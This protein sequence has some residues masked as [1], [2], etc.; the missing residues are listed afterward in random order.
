MDRHISPT[1]KRIL[2]ILFVLAVSLALRVINLDA[3]PSALISR[4]FIT[5]EG[6]WAHNARNAVI[7]DQL[8]VDDYNPGLYSAFLYHN[9]LQLAFSAFGMSIVSARLVSAVAGWFTVVLLFDWIRREIDT[10]TAVIGALLL[11][12]STL[13]VLYSRTGFVE[14]TLVFFLALALWLWSI[15]RKHPAFGALSGIAFDLMVVT[16]VTAIYIVPGIALLAVAEA[17][18]KT[19]SKRD[20][21]LFICGASIVF[22]S[23][24]V[25]FVI[26]NYTSWIDYNLAAGFDNEFPRHW[27]ELVHSVL[28]LLASRFFARVPILTAL[29]LV[30]L[31]ALVFRISISG[32]KNAVRNACGIEITAIALL[33]GYLLSIAP[34]VYQPERRFVPVLFLMVPISANALVRGWDWFEELANEPGL[35]AV[36]W[37]LFLFSLPTLAIIEL[38]WAVL[39]TPLTFRSWLLKA[40]PVLLLIF[41]SVSLGRG[42]LSHAVRGRLL[43][44][45]KLVFVVLFSGLSLGLVYQSLRLWGFNPHNFRPG[46]FVVG[47]TV[48]AIVIAAIFGLK[49]KPKAAQVA[50]AAFVSIEALQT[51]TWFLQQTYTLK[52]ANEALVGIVKDGQTVIT[53]YETMLLSSTARTICYW[54]RA[55]FNVD[56][57]ERFNPDYI[58][59]LRRDN[60]TDHTLGDMPTDEWPPPTSAAPEFVAR[61]DLCPTETRGFRFSLELYRLVP[62]ELVPTIR[63]DGSDNRELMSTSSN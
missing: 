46:G 7:F 54:P 59:I 58:L 55:G 57:F 50:L 19:T 26:P 15:R 38:K 6:Q 41:V 2:L 22:A 28:S 5:D 40:I 9:L 60:W 39:G 1:Q 3:D 10:R 49:I 11:G 37:F 61:F 18:R 8:R 12:L 63:S 44:G 16:K 36:I 23:Y 62:S 52:R 34:T 43:S 24:A 35:R 21:L 32:L 48:L 29:T 53:H 14:S 33:V 51:S 45:S 27:S 20:A 42:R 25:A 13:H 56:A 17:I 31:G 30:S 4:D 47:F